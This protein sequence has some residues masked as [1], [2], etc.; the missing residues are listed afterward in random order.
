LVAKNVIDV[1]VGSP[2]GYRL[3]VVVGQEFTHFFLLPTI[4]HT[5]INHYTFTTVFAPQYIG[6]LL[7][8]VEGESL[9]LHGAK[10]GLAGKAKTKTPGQSPG[11][12]IPEGSY[13]LISS[14]LWKLAPNS[15]HSYK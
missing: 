15:T 6:V 7:Q 11:A 10:I 4:V 13:R 3:K 12:S 8:G 9:N 14:R 2:N 1:S 5:R